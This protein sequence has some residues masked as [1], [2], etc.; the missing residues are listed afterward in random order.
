[1]MKIS[2]VV[3]DDEQSNRALIIKLV[4]QLDSCFEIIGE[5]ADLDEAYEV[6]TEK[7]PHVVFLD[8]KMPSGNGFDLLER[9]ENIDF[10]VVFIS[11]FDS[12]ALKAFE[13]N[14]LDYVV[15][16][17]NSE[18]FSKTLERIKTRLHER[19]PK[20]QDLKS[21]IKSYDLQQ[22]VISKISI[23]NGN[24]VFF[25]N[26]EEIVWIKSESKCTTFKTSSDDKY[27]SSKELADFSFILADHPYMVKVSKNTYINLNFVQFYSKGQNCLI[28]MKDGMVIEVPRRKKSEILGLMQKD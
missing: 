2:S 9:F 18:K 14:A 19:A 21:I 8:I 26:I 4:A 12:Y 20:Q 15:K 11:G 25:L 22:L 10:E 5:A 28:T 6:I 3:I 13:F 7:K 27:F 23:H 17:I 16:P 24:N 1:M